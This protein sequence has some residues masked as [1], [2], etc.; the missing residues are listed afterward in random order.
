[1]CSTTQSPRSANA[2]SRA[3]AARTCPAPEDA[4][5]SK[6]RGFAF[7][8]GELRFWRRASRSFAASG[9]DLFED[10][11]CHA[12]QLA[13]AHQIILEFVIQRFR[14]FRA[15]LRAQNHIAQLDGM[16]QKR[17]FLQFFERDARVVVIHKFPRGEEGLES[18][19]RGL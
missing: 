7:I 13:K 19:R 15:K 16:R 8:R 3:C 18:L 14:F 6:T 10:S 11:A 4:D 17:V 2:F 9:G 12:L 5:R 1:M